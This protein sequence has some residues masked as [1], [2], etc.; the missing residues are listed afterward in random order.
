VSYLVQFAKRAKV[1]GVLND[2]IKSREP[3]FRFS[4][5][6]LSERPF[7]DTFACVCAVCALWCVVC[8]CVC[9]L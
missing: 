4:F 3:T 1:L 8:V 9:V 2:L 7:H 5:V 6:R